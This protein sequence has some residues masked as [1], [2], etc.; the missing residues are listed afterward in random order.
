MH[1]TTTE[2]S[3]CVA[4][5]VSVWKHLVR[6]SDSEY[7]RWPPT[8][9][10]SLSASKPARRRWTAT[11]RVE[12]LEVPPVDRHRHH[13]EQAAVLVAQLTNGRRGETTDSTVFTLADRREIFDTYI[14]SRVK[15]HD[16]MVVLYALFQWSTVTW[17]ATAFIR[18]LDW[19][20]II[21]ARCTLVQSAV[22]RSHVVCLSVCPSVCDVGGLWWHT[23]EFF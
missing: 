19:K 6:G 13:V 18:G 9:V 7:C 16:A 17:G 5:L 22:L 21:T 20:C 12:H 15:W 2:I 8:I 1:K 3:R 14:C 4:G 11:G 10:R 23:L